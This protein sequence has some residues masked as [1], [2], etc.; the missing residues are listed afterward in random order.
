MRFSVIVP[1]Y[2]AEKYIRQ[3]IDSIL[4]QTFVDF[5][6]ILVDDGS[7]DE[8]PKICDEYADIDNR[9]EVIHKPNGGA[10]S[11][12]KAGLASAK[13]EYILCVDGD[14]CIASNLLF[15]MNK[16]ISEFSCDVICFGYDTFPNQARKNDTSNYREG[17][18][19]KEQIEKEIFPTLIT[20]ENGVRFPPS[21][22]SKVFK[23][24]LLISVQNDLPNEIIIGE[25]SCISYVSIFQAECIY[26]SHEALYLYR[27]ENTSLTRSKKAFSWVEPL[28][29][30]D[31][32]LKNMP[33][34]Q[35]EEQVARITAHS[36]F[37]VAISVLR[38]KK[39]VEAKEEI[40]EKLSDEKAQYY[41]RLAKFNN[42]KEQLALYCL[43]KKLVLIMKILSKVA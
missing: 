4:E 28:L 14:D 11:A 10:T 18:Y 29:R 8:C 41:L 36:F 19:N 34:D 42:K 38:A 20:G 37:N 5:Q 2:K 1:I 16:I 33:K 26:I 30:A 32:Y 12:R 25:D 43:R 17:I 31:F 13:G 22:W 40:I 7:L 9:V 23:R 21:I 24:E 35:F 6:L 27:V 15:E 3:C 39:Y